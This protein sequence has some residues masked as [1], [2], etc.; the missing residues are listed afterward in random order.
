MQDMNGPSKKSSHILKFLSHYH[1]NHNWLCFK[2]KDVINFTRWANGR[3]KDGFRKLLIANDN[4]NE[5]FIF[6]KFKSN[7][8]L[9]SK[10]IQMHE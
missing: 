2:K 9:K 6:L 10:E 5:L 7:L 4:C 1:P 3:T 8:K